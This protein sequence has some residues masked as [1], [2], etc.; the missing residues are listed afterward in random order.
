[1]LADTMA[2]VL[3]EDV[4]FPV[5]GAQT[6]ESAPRRTQS[7]VSAGKD[8]DETR[9]ARPH[10]KGAAESA[11]AEGQAVPS[12]EKEPS[13]VAMAGAGMRTTQRSNKSLIIGGGLVVLLLAGVVGLLAWN[14]TRAKTSD[15]A[16]MKS[17]V[18]DP[19]SAAPVMTP[20]LSYWIESFDQPKK[21]DTKRVADLV[22]PL[23]SGQNYKFYFRPS[24]RGYFYIIGQTKAGNAPMT[25]LTAQGDDLRK[26][27]L[28]P[29]N[30]EFD[31]PYQGKLNLDNNPGTDEFTI[32][33][34]P[35][36]LLAPAFLSEKY[37]HVLTP[38]EVKELEDFRAQHK[39]TDVKQFVQPENN[40]DAVVVS[41]P[42]AVNDRPVIFEIY[43]KHE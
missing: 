35:T 27:N 24:A 40:E 5:I 2:T 6:S 23:V 8:K 42:G 14:R 7:A 16:G 11:V 19:N 21:G 9:V 41:V 29:G 37:R 18:A 10:L 20:V 36:P 13:A 31:F 38:A 1:M 15:D 30:A 33:F 3:F 12:T 4:E 17:T 26:T 22:I 28:A 43:I 25:F 39:L 32:I 34:S